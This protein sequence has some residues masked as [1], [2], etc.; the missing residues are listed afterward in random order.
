MEDIQSAGSAQS[1]F[2][3][4]LSIVT[5]GYVCYYFIAFSEKKFQAI[6]TLLNLRID[7]VHQVIFQKM[8]GFVFMGLFP[9]VTAAF[10]LPERPW[11]YGLS[12]LYHPHSIYWLL[13]SAAIIIPLNLMF[14][15]SSENLRHYP[16]IRMQRWTREHYFIEHCRVGSLF[17]GL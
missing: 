8:T 17:A 15:G 5:L 11:D 9:L 10:C 14:A 3:I 6:C 2:I 13:I 12:S 7:S 1:E 16:Q 4:V